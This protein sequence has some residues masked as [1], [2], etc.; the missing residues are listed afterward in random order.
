MKFLH[1]ADLHLGRRPL[2]GR[3]L[4]SDKRYQDYFNAFDWVIHTAIEKQADALLIAGDMFD[5]RELSPEVLEK[6]E[7]SL[8]RL[9]DNNIRTLLIEGNHDNI[10][11]GRETESWLIFLERKGLISR[12]VCTAT[13]ESYSFTPIVI[14]DIYFYGAGYPGAFADEVLTVLAEKLDP[15]KKNIVL[16]HTAIGEGDFIPGTCSSGAIKPF[17]E[18]VLYI[19]GGHLH[20]YKNYPK[21]DPYFFVPGAPEY[22]DLGEKNKRGSILFDTESGNHSFIPSTPRRKLELNMEITKNSEL[23]FKEQFTALLEGA[24]ITQEEDLMIINITQNFS[25]FID[26]TWCEQTASEMGALKALIRVTYPHEENSLNDTSRMPAEQVEEELIGGWDVFASKKKET[27]R[28]LQKLKTA[29]I[30]NRLEQFLEEFDGLLETFLQQ[31]E[32]TS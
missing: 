28:I 14:D 15:N 22:W 26:T 13:E 3:G 8:A 21:A 4:Y 31:E 6:A 18:K 16:V 5:R 29:Q 1:C 25:F 11:S 24:D 30:E 7:S 19:A 10:T 32:K 12:P 23:D 17:K 9:K 27:A 20:S 2:G